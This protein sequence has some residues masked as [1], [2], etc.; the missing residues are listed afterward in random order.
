MSARAGAIIGLA[1]FVAAGVIALLPL[2]T[3]DVLGGPVGWCGPG[4]S[5]ASALRVA[6]QP[7]IVRE[8]PDAGSG[9]A[10]TL[11]QVCKG[12]ADDRLTEAA[13]TGAAAAVLGAGVWWIDDRYRKGYIT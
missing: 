3:V 5:S 9:A 11:E 1:G 13:L 10:D 2:P 7:E 8:G 12:Q 4:T 6:T